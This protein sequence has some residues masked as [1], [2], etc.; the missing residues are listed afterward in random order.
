MQFKS[1]FVGTGAMKEFVAEVTRIAN[2]LNNMRIN[3]PPS[4]GG[5]DPVVSI[6]PN[7]IVLDFQNTV[8]VPHTEAE[9]F[10]NDTQETG[11]G[12]G[13]PSGTV[14]CLL[15]FV[16]TRGWEVLDPPLLTN[17]DNRRALLIDKGP[18]GED[19]V[20]FWGPALPVGVEN[21]MLYR[22]EDGWVTLGAPETW[23]E[24]ESKSLITTKGAINDEIS[25]GDGIP[26]GAKGDILIHDGTGWKPL[27]GVD[28][29]TVFPEMMLKISG[30]AGDSL[31]KWDFVRAS[32]YIDPETP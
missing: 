3:M 29:L 27:S 6:T 5:V 9:T 1:N 2:A 13:L 16:R 21:D 4:M 14:N 20:L 22:G 12:D 26:P 32:N 31:P 10:E 23:E 11:G 30:T 15:R 7:G 25:W 24:G 17:D 19:D 28:N 18:E 8:F